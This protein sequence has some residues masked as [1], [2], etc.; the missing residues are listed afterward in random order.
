MIKKKKMLFRLLISVAI[1]VLV[2]GAGYLILFCGTDV[3]QIEDNKIVGYKSTWLTVSLPNDNGESVYYKLGDVSAPRNYTAVK[4][5]PDTDEDPYTTLFSFQGKSEKNPGLFLIEGKAIDA[6]QIKAALENAEAEWQRPS[7]YPGAQEKAEAAGWGYRSVGT[8]EKAKTICVYP[9]GSPDCTDV[10]CLVE[11]PY[12]GVYAQITISLD[13]PA[14]METWL[15]LASLMAE[16][17]TPGKQLHPFVADFKLNF[18]DDNRWVYLWDGL[19]ITLLITLLATILGV[20]IGVIV[21][22]VCSTWDKNNERMVKGPGKFFLAA[23]NKVCRV[24]LTVI[25][26]TPVVI[27][28]M[29]FYF[30]I[31]VSVRDISVSFFGLKTVVKS[32]V[33]VSI[34]AFGINSGA[35]VA[36]IIRGG[37]MSIDPGQMEAGRSLGFNY[38]QTMFYIVIPQALKNVLPSLA[39]EFIVLLKETSVAGYAAVIDLTKAG[40]IIKGVTYSPFLPLIAVALIYLIMVMF[41]TRLV[42]RLER[43]LRNSDH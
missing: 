11:T 41:F 27:Q 8:A 1:A 10:Y 12:E 23:A 14:E 26:G 5:L 36:E 3:L 35:Y 37:I 21:A 24:F 15:S 7:V 34:I 29:L 2:A 4:D 32:G 25:R 40:D 6:A 18:I 42:A 39:N 17:V 22:G 38:I 20:I 19:K 30:V 9:A 16:K 28:L 31:L 43:R 13:A 33:I